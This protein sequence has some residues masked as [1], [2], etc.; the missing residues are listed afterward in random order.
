MNGVM[1]K[2]SFSRTQKMTTK[3]KKN[4]DAESYKT[5]YA[6]G[7]LAVTEEIVNEKVVKYLK[8]KKSR[9][10]SNPYFGNAGKIKLINELIEHFE[11]ECFE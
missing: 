1:V 5:G 6:A 4:F 3:P 10:D 7:S 11:S 2:R 9:L 8:E